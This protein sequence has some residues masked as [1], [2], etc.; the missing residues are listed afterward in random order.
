HVV[1]LFALG[2]LGNAVSA[3]FSPASSSILPFIVE[4]EK[5]QQ[6]NSCFSILSSFQAIVGVVLAGILYVA[7]SVRT[8]FLLV[9]ACYLLSG[10]SE[11]FIRYDYRWPEGTMTIKSAL[12]D[13]KEGFVYL[14]KEKAILA[15][16]LS[17]LFINFFCTPIF[18]NFF[19]YF[20]A[21]EVKGGGHY[22][23]D[24]WI[25][26]ELWNSITTVCFG[27]GS[28]VAGFLIGAQKPR[29]KC[30]G[31]VKICLS[32]MSVI[33]FGLSLVYLFAVERGDNVSAFLIAMSIGL[34][35]IGALIVFINVP[36]STTIQR[37]VDR[38]LLGKVNSV[39][40]ATSQGLIP[41]ACFLAGIVLS[42]WGCMPMLFLCSVGFLVTTVSLVF[43]RAVR[44]I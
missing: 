13:M 24:Q 15:L 42:T 39:L 40:T 14:S 5:L 41:I 4:E 2:I 11:M 30:S 35:I 9:G 43:N 8:L 38:R 32:G 1:V 37:V 10:L 27:V 17:M 18:E 31:I 12:T 16:M 36:I 26:P 23:F 7:M 20:I 44:N 29:E 6:A 33:L 22:L 3:I 21:T 28:L 34:I 25:E 19:P